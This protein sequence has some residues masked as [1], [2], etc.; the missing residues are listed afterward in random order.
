M[1]PEARLVGDIL[2]A[3]VCVVAAVL[4]VRSRKIPNALTLPPV[5]VGLLLAG[6]GGGYDLAAAATAAALLGG[7][8][9]LFAAVGGVGWGDA[10]LMAAVG[11]LLGWPLGSWSIVLYALLYTALA[12]GL[13]ALVVALRKRR[14]GAALKGVAT[15]ARRRRVDE[16]HSSGVTIPYALPIAV[17]ALWAIAARYVPE[18][19]L[20]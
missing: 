16:S 2:C 17:G 8:F 9:A 14:L 11:A 5:A 7:L 10:K 18:L 6:S 15:M 13:V 4:D 12:G 20:G 19:L 1:I 3:V